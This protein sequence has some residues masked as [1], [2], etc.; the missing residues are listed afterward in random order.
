[1]GEENSTPFETMRRWLREPLLHFLV[2]GAVFSAAHGLLQRR[3]AQE[4][5]ANRI[6]LTFDDLR[7][8]ER[9]FE[10]QWRRPPTQQEFA[11][12]LESRIREE[13]LYREAL[14]IGLDKEDTIVKRRMAQKMEFLAEDLSALR[15]PSREE[16]RAWFESNAQRFAYPPRISFHHLYFSFDKH[17]G[18]PQQAAAEAL[19]KIA[20]KSSDSSEARALADSFMFQDYYADRPP[21][22]V[23]RVFG[24]NFATSLFELRPGAWQGP[25]ESGY[26]WHLVF[27]DSKTPS[28]VPKFEEVEANVKAA[29]VVDQRTE[30]KR[31]AYEAMR[32]RYEVVLPTGLAN[33]TPIGNKTARKEGR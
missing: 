29:W 17:S 11:G 18:K 16:L 9:Y 6:E 33:E 25:I 2:I 13:I 7:Q 1:M 22:Q 12:L 28:R 32:A 21:D 27:V 5:S 26:G 19:K 10:S 8:L 30:F 20:G 14:A 24:G 31:K 3:V 4:E 15:Q 23:R